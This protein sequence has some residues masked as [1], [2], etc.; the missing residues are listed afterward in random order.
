[1]IS[2]LA[3]VV[4]KD[5]VPPTVTTPE[6]TRSPREL[7]AFRLPPMALLPS[8]SPVAALLATVASPLTETLVSPE[9]ATLR[10]RLVASPSVTFVAP[11]TVT[12]L[13]KSLVVC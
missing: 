13:L 4:L 1:M 6:S 7:L 3:V 9:L 5:A 12:V 11:V 10:V 2:L 8:F